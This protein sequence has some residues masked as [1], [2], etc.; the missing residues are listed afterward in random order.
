MSTFK[1]NIRLVL[2][3]LGEVPNKEEDSRC[4]AYRNAFNLTDRD[5][6]VYER[7]LN[8]GQLTINVTAPSSW[9]VVSG[10]PPD[11]FYR[12]LLFAMAGTQ[13]SP[14]A[15]M[16]SSPRVPALAPRTAPRDIKVTARGIQN[17][18]VAWEPPDGADCTGEL[19]NYVISINSSRL[20]EPMIIKVPREKRSYVVNDLVPGTQYTVQVA[21]T[22]RGGVGVASKPLNFRTGGETP[23]VDLDD[24][25][26]VEGAALVSEDPEEWGNEFYEGLSSRQEWIVD[27]RNTYGDPGMYMVPA[28]IH[29]LRATAT[30]NS[31]HLKWT[32]A[33]RRV[34]PETESDLIMV[35][36]RNGPSRTAE[37]SARPMRI[38]LSVNKHEKDTQGYLPS[39]TKYLIRWGDMHP[40]P[41][42]DTVRGD[43]T[44]YLIENLRPGTIYYI[45][46]IAVTQLGE[47]PAAYTVTRTLSSMT[48]NLSRPISGPLI[49]VNLVVQAVGSTWARVG[50]ELPNLPAP[51]TMPS[52][53]FQIK[54]YAITAD[55]FNE[56][57]RGRGSGLSAYERDVELVNLTVPNRNRG[58][59]RSGNHFKAMLRGLR[60]GTQY[61]FGVCLIQTH[62]SNDP[63]P[64]IAREG[65]STTLAASPY[66]WSMVQGFETFGQNP[67][68]PPHHIRVLIP[69]SPTRSDNVDVLQFDPADSR[70]LPLDG[71]NTYPVRVLWD[72]PLQ[73]NGPIVAY[74]IYLTNRKQ[75]IAHWLERSVDGALRRVELR[76]LEADR[77]YYMR[78][79]ARNRHGRSPLSPVVV[80]RTPDVQGIGGGMFK[81]SRDYY[82]AVDINEPLVTMVTGISET[83]GAD[84]A[85][86]KG[87]SVPWIV[88]GSVLGGALVI[89]I[90]VTVILLNRCRK[91][92]TSL[93]LMKGQQPK[94]PYLA[95]YPNFYHTDPNRPA[96]IGQK[97]HNFAM[98]DACL[99]SCSLSGSATGGSQP[100]PLGVRLP[101]TTCGA[102]HD[103]RHKHDH[104]SHI[105]SPPQTS[106]CQC[107]EWSSKGLTAHNHTCPNEA[108][109]TCCNSVDGNPQWISVG[110]SCQMTLGGCL[111]DRHSTPAGSE[112]DVSGCG[113]GGLRRM[114]PVLG[115]K[116]SARGALESHDC[117]NHG[118]PRTDH[119]GGCIK[120]ENWPRGANENIHSLLQPPRDMTLSYLASAHNECHGNHIHSETCELQH[121]LQTQ[122]QTQQQQQQQQSQH[123]QQQKKLPFLKTHTNNGYNP[124]Q[125]SQLSAGERS[126]EF[127]YMQSRHGAGMLANHGF[128]GSGSLNDDEAI[129]SSPASSSAGRASAGLTHLSTSQ[130]HGNA[131][132]RKFQQSSLQGLGKSDVDK[133]HGG[134][135]PQ[136]I[137]VF[138][139][140]VQ[141]TYDGRGKS[142]KISEYKMGRPIQSSVTSNVMVDVSP[143]I[144]QK[145]RIGNFGNPTRVNVMSSDYASQQS[146][147][148]NPS[149]ASSNAGFGF[150]PERPAS[151][152]STPLGPDSQLTGVGLSF[153]L[154]RVP[155]PEPT[156]RPAPF[157]RLAAG[158]LLNTQI[159]AR[160][161]GNREEYLGS[162]DATEKLL[163]SPLLKKS[164][165]MTAPSGF[166]REHT[167]DTPDSISEKE[168]MRGYSAEELNQE[169]ANLEGLMKDLNQ[170]TQNQFDC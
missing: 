79:A 86:L 54:Y 81:L 167:P 61:E 70:E 160:L 67:K 38:S 34:N 42:E 30:Q 84:T 4:M 169:M 124:I 138:P 123:Q 129:T 146:S 53:V 88:V 65:T 71:V 143:T 116:L 110:H 136:R 41:A 114:D 87:E 16:P 36:L 51:E 25:E 157:S 162:S 27:D 149:S 161:P 164:E 119:S 120:H 3:S 130:T 75:T 150:S 104:S 15:S 6:S 127:V 13:R 80:F 125:G 117:Y 131:S 100:G 19:I 141:T 133:L 73:S 163:Q 22:T 147:L 158:D 95:A 39:G 9:T 82:D 153:A 142:L 98:P 134:I 96:D 112:K 62:L 49:P 103:S 135:S 74:I 14:P 59:K 128:T 105:V 35:G 5:V 44:E 91:G 33:L 24:E 64:S 17:A 77:V 85:E 31:I 145:H 58:T 166:E 92:R 10:L 121:N 132:M 109:C 68:D 40:G 63:I 7:T 43:Q 23:R 26:D 154:D 152:T 11:N 20:L 144:Q 8:Q 108:K 12:V 89:M 57:Q 18:K 168:L 107:S 29:N 52:M 1:R 159:N 122:Q 151:N 46:V 28:K 139:S 126:P 115:R 2:I 101:E 165:L 170:I 72:A 106:S 93:G 60:P 78:I 83:S 118:Y 47:G 69:E 97:V 66:C 140:T 148:S 37:P 102:T 48:D 55:G 111:D 50:W 45:R 156:P 113:S 21:A 56:H 94:Q 90:V 155:T 99:G 32:V 76:G 137:G